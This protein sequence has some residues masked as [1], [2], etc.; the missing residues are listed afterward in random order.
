VS[1]IKT[2]ELFLENEQLISNLSRNFQIIHG[3]YDG[4]IYHEYDPM[5]EIEYDREKLA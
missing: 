4:P 3:C 2:V 1:D 5:A